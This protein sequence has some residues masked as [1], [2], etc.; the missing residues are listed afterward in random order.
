MVANDFRDQNGMTMRVHRPES[1]PATAEAAMALQDELRPLVDRTNPRAPEF[2]TVAGLDSAY[3]ESG[4]VAAA[5]VVLDAATLRPLETAVAHGTTDFP[6]VPG[7][8]AF[9]ELPTSLTVLEKLRT[10]PDLIVC[11]SQGLAHPRRFGFA[12]HLGILTGIPT[13]GVA[14]SAW[15]DYTEP[16][17]ERGASTDLLIDGEV[18]GRALR[19]R[20]G[21]KPVFVSI[22][23]R[24]DLDTACAQVLALTPAYRQPETTRR[25]DRLCRQALLDLPDPHRPV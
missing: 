14:K 4:V 3:D 24:I 6:Y 2:R 5:A 11:D 25:A 13:L 19:T 10:T 17:P 8:L 16:A 23:H 12:C 21:V 15:G 1:W 18:V 9:R 7:L 20:T 22:G